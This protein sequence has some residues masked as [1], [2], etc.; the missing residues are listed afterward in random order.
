MDE[1]VE[2]TRAEQIIYGR[3][4]KQ[5]RAVRDFDD[6]EVFGKAIMTDCALVDGHTR[7]AGLSKYEGVS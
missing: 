7:L 3:V 5:I 4:L 2:L 1:K 6:V